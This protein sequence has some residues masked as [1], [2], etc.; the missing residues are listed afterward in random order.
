VKVAKT[1][2]LRDLLLVVSSA[3]LMLLSLPEAD[4]GMLAWVC[5]VPWL[6]ALKDKSLK[7]AFVLSYVAGLCVFTGMTYWLWTVPAFHVIDFIALCGYFPHYLSLWGLGLVWMHR[8]TGWP[9]VLIGPPL[10][11]ALEFVRSH[12]TFLSAPWMLLGH[13]QYLHPT[14]VQL[15]SL[16]GVY[17]LSFLI[18]LFNMGL[19]HCLTHSRQTDGWANALRS[20]AMSSASF[21]ATVILLLGVW[22]YGRMVVEAE[23]EP[24][25]V[26]V[27]LIQANFLPEVQWNASQRL[28]VLGRYQELTRQAALA[29]PQLIIWP[30]SAVPGDVENDKD[31]RAFVSR[32]AIESD[33]YLLVGS[34]EKGK[35]VDQDLA[36]RYFNSMVL[37]A[38]DGRIAGQYRKIGLVPFA[39]YVP[40]E[41]LV[42][43]PKFIVS[44]MGHTVPGHEYTVLHAG[45]LNVGALICWENIFPDL[46]REFVSGGAQMMINA[47]NE[48]WFGPTAAPYQLLAMATFRAA[49]NRIALARAS[50]TGVT[51]F[52]DPYGRITERLQD[53]HGGDLFIEGMLIGLV[54]VKNGPMTFYTRHGDVFA[55]VQVVFFGICA[56]SIAGRSLR[57]SL[58]ISKEPQEDGNAAGS[59]ICTGLRS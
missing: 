49:E 58:V 28:H 47:T 10:W 43:W 19:A 3:A 8:R 29:S 11:V 17:G 50:N 1:L 55:W 15:S 7:Q 24:D 13:S 9:A 59:Q 52:I 4:F 5:L 30:E 25:R 39:E 37:F 34:S 38:P 6:W 35:F 57:H 16:T 44:L 51:A 54:P 46:F 26:K 21:G 12:F 27:A 33:A 48:S 2:L 14:I 41:G 23:T 22:L 45:S 42:T 40:L 31:L 36:G 18:V 20:G 56:L 32:I 53:E